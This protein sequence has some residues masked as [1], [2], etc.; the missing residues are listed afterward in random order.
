MG[1]SLG[2]VCG[3]TRR[4]C[5]K[6]KITFKKKCLP[7]WLDRRLFR[8]PRMLIIKLTSVTF[9][10]YIKPC[11]GPFDSTS[12]SIMIIWRKPISFQSKIRLWLIAVFC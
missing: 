1:A 7:S 4:L 8:P 11:T 5:R 6:I 3:V 10:F 12:A 2:E 9:N